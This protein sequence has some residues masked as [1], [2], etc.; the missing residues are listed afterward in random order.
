MLSYLMIDKRYVNCYFNL[1]LT[2]NRKD[3]MTKRVM[4]WNLPIEEVEELARENK[5][6]TMTCV[7]YNDTNKEESEDKDE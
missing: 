3:N 6:K 7:E 1:I 4:W 2:I 5:L